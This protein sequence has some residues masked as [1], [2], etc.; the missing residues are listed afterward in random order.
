MP[1]DTQLSFAE[2]IRQ[3]SYRQLCDLIEKLADAIDYYREIGLEHPYELSALIGQL[4]LL[5]QNINASRKKPTHEDIYNMYL[6]GKKPKQIYKE[7]D[8][9]SY[10]FI[11]ESIQ[12]KKRQAKVKN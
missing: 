9:Y 2:A 1:N 4:N 10:W 8:Y 12:K 3:P 11:T 7:L 5:Q 6:A